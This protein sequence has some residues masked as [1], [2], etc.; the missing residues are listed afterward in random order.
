MIVSYTNL[1]VNESDWSLL[2]YNL[3]Y[4]AISN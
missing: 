2:S 4:M 3:I 1:I